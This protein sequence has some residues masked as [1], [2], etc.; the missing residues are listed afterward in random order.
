MEPNCITILHIEDNQADAV[1]IQEILF[2]AKE[3]SSTV[4]HAGLLSLGMEIM[5]AEA[6]DV[7]LLDL[8]LPDSFGE[9][10]GSTEQNSHGWRQKRQPAQHRACSPFAVRR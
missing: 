1:L 2:D 9:I 6:V 3:F 5:A 4:R 7:I 8:S 10:T